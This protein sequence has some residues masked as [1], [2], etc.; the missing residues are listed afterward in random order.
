MNLKLWERIPIFLVVSLKVLNLLWR[1]RRTQTY[2]HFK[3]YSQF[4]NVR[5]ISI[6]YHLR[7]Y[8]RYVTYHCNGGIQFDWL[9]SPLPLHSHRDSR[10]L[11]FPLDPVVESLTVLEEIVLLSSVFSKVSF[12]CLSSNLWYLFIVTWSDLMNIL[13]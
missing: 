1:L 9:I 11:I 13:I 8:F 7:Q 3:R 10:L 6:R 4:L 12:G 2:K 5:I